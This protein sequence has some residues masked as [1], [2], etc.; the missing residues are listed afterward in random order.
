[1]S[2]EAIESAVGISCEKGLTPR[3]EEAHAKARR[4]K[5]GEAGGLENGFGAFLFP[6]NLGG[7]A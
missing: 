7:F 6:K 3:R 5:E 1:M 4:R 2:G